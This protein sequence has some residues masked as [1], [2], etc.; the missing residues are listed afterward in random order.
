MIVIMLHNIYS[1]IAYIIFGEIQISFL[2]S[3]HA[4]ALYKVVASEKGCS[5]SVVKETWLEAG[6]EAGCRQPRKR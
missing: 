1:A 6:G 3:L 5:V 4:A 2:S